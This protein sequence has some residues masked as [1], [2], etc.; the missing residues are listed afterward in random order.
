MYLK[1]TMNIIIIIII[2]IIICWDV[3]VCLYDEWFS[4]N[5]FEINCVD[6]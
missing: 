1:V 2:I 4:F 3:F 5:I 6:Q